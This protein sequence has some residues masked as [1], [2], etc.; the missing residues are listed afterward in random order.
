MP[1]STLHLPGQ[2]KCKASLSHFR[3]PIIAARPR[4][5][6]GCHRTL[7]HHAQEYPRG[8]HPLPHPRHPPL[9]AHP[10]RPRRR[11]LVHQ[12]LRPHPRLR[13]GRPW[14]PATRRT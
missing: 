13:P 5:R 7:R 14:P 2:L 3:G 6:P 4:Q 12:R 10:Y 11:R 8:L 1:S 9:P